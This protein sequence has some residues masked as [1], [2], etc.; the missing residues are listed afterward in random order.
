M[1]QWDTSGFVFTWGWK[2]TAFSGSDVPSFRAFGRLCLYLCVVAA[3][4]VCV[5]VDATVSTQLQ[6]CLF[7]RKQGGY[8]SFVKC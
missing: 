1:S 4:S 8:Q 5:Y 2:C 3:I 7:G 6:L